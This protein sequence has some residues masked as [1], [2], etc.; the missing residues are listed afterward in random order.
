MIFR[1]VLALAIVAIADTVN[2]LVE[3]VGDTGFIQLEADSFSRLDARQQALAYWL[4]QASIA[5]DPIIYDQLSQ[6]GI[7]EKRLL[8]GIVAIE[9]PAGIRSFALLFW[10]NRGNHNETT[11]QK[12]LP[13]F[14]FE[15]LQRAA[16]TA[17]D[18]GAFKTAYADLAPLATRE[19]LDR[20]LAELRSALFDPNVE[21][22]A[23]AKTPPPGKDIL[24]A[25]SNTFYRGVTL[26]D[27]KAVTERYRLNSRVVKGSDGTVREDVYRAGTPDGR[28]PPGAY[29]TFLKKAIG[30][31]ER[32]RAVADP[33][34]ARVIGDLIRY[35]QTGERSDWLQFGGDWVRNDATVDFA[36][37]FIEVYRDA[38]GAKGSAQSFV[39]IT[40]KPVTDAMTKLAQN[41]AYFEEK[42]PWAPKYKKQAF[43]PP[44][45]KAVQL[46]VET[47]DFHVTTIGD[48]LPN[49]N[50][51]HERYGTKN[52]L[53]LGSSH[54]LSAASAAKIGG[55]FIASA[56]EAERDRK[57]GELA[58][59]LKVAMHEVI[60]HG[61]GKLTERVKDGAESHL[62]E[63]FS[64]LEEARADLMALWNIGDRKLSELQLVK[65]QEEVARA[66]Y[67]AA[68]RVAL[69]QLRRI[70]R[71]DTIEEDHQRDRQ[72]IV[73][74]IKDTTGAIEYFDR[75]GKTY[76]R[77]K[78]YR[79]MREG[80]GTLLAEL[81]RIKA[82]GDYDAIKALIDKYAVHFDPAVRDQ[83]VSR[84]KQ[85]DLP[86]Y[87]AGINVHLDAQL[88]ANGNV[89]SVRASYPRDAVKQYL[90]YGKM[91][92]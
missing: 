74:F 26:N 21:P 7:R 58:E 87:W 55:E 19:A 81:M 64:A 79:K 2:P 72:L 86:T 9:A 53:F 15:E 80:V 40:D 77:V 11:A 47:G 22:T 28:V 27:L 70:P 23:T 68:A 71:G 1:I 16:H 25:S 62:K 6:Y 42:A 88:D 35:Y 56:E 12:F 61:S 89:T 33:A 50:E 20:E 5:I 48:N 59:D 90:A 57:Y 38:R 24:Q 4:T 92:Q 66:M 8:E 52:F 85:L 37:G 76:V 10:A 91:Y 34:Q 14:T 75:G 51:I 45:V 29:A 60:G 17:Q 84:Y 13:A 46:L 69:T 78:D 18:R 73:N 65:D 83:V 30:H 67:D 41:A 54:A 49:E 39:S 32:A 31:L 3:R 36:N 63:Y 44:V 43:S 82:E